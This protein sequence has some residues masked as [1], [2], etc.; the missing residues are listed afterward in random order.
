MNFPT[1]R[2]AFY[3]LSCGDVPIALLSSAHIFLLSLPTSSTGL[4]GRGC[5][6]V[7]SLMVSLVGCRKGDFH[8]RKVWVPLSQDRGSAKLSQ[9]T[10]KGCHLIHI[11]AQL[12]WPE[13]DAALPKGACS[14]GMATKEG[15]LIPQ[16]QWL[17][18]AS[19]CFL[20]GCKLVRAPVRSESCAVHAEVSVTRDRETQMHF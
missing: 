3:S 4:Q 19:V 7:P 9:C 8:K 5:N 11:T 15:S 16:P 10:H 1:P 12:S 20:A 13:A 2:C 18:R 17:Q 14:K 6:A